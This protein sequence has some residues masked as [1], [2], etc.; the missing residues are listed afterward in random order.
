MGNEAIGNWR[1]GQS[2]CELGRCD[3]GCMR[4]RALEQQVLDNMSLGM[5]QNILAKDNFDIDVDIQINQHDPGN[6]LRKFGNMSL[7]WPAKQRMLCN[8]G[9]LGLTSACHA[10]KTNKWIQT[11]FR[12]SNNS[13]LNHLMF[14]TTSQST[15]HGYLFLKNPVLVSTC[16]YIMIRVNERPVGVNEQF[17]YVSTSDASTPQVSTSDAST[18]QVSTSD[19]SNSTLKAK[20]SQLFL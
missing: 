1:N 8:D 13:N 14:K 9:R 2:A 10:T 5:F 19:A 12:I 7:A 3:N 4:P 6:W 18:P 20:Q 11:M 17:Q 16:I 15:W